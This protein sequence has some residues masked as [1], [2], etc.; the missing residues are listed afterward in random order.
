MITLQ[1]YIW[2]RVAISN[3]AN[4]ILIPLFDISS[5]KKMGTEGNI[6]FIDI[7]MWK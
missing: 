5:Y 2:S 1:K 7:K 4:I 6:I 3:S